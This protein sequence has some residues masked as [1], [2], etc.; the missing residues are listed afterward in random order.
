MASPSSPP[1]PV[2]VDWETSQGVSLSLATPHLF[3][4]E[5]LGSSCDFCP[6]LLSGLFST[7]EHASDFISPTAVSLD[8]KQDVPHSSCFSLLPHVDSAVREKET[9]FSNASYAFP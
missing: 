8:C 9:I 2:M 4:G 1:R 5:A 6:G 7:L 3:A